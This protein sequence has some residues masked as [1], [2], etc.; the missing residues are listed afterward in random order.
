MEK[1]VKH[2]IILFIILITPILIFADEKDAKIFEAVEQSVVYIE[3][4][5]FLNKNDFNNQE[6]IKKIEKEYKSNILD[7]YLPI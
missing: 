5:V 6:I 2:I 4:S 1:K 3:A 7:S